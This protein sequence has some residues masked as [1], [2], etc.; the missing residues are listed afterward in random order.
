[1]VCF[2]GV[3]VTTFCFLEDTA[4]ATRAMDVVCLTLIAFLT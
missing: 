2:F 3:V 4:L 1:M